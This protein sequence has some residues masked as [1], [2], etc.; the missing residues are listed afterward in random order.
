MTTTETKALLAAC[1]KLA[2]ALAREYGLPLD[3]CVS[4]EFADYRAAIA[5]ASE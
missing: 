2:A 4:L 5:A 3:E 1:H